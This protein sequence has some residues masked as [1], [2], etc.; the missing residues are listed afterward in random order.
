M[1]DELKKSRPVEVIADAEPVALG[2]I[3]LTLVEPHK[4]HEVEYNRW[5][6]R[7]HF[8]SGVMIGPYSFA[9]KRFVATNDLK[10]LRSPD[11]SAI[12]GT[13]EN[14]SYIA[15]YWVLDGYHDLWN[16]WS[17]RQ[18]RQLH[19]KGRMFEHRDHVHTLLYHYEWSVLRDEGGVPIELAL[20]HPYEG[21]VPVWIDAAEGVSQE[22]LW[23]Y[24]KD[25][26]L[27][28]LMNGSAAGLVGA[29]TPLPLLID[30]P[31]DVPRQE[32]S[33]DRVLLL[34]FLDCDPSEAWESVF[35]EGRRRLEA[36]GKGTLVAQIPFKPTAPGTDRYTDQLWDA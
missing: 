29:F 16:K 26:L 10:K 32:A 13:P 5:Y 2:S 21:F 30:A 8:Y 14:G 1:S 15:A 25:D 33:D 20:D 11:S 31:G 22:E 36:S 28:D 19:A 35:E 17:V 18:V 4:G 23:G 12:T 24:L 27:P 34:F 6:E 9:G 3:L 7:D